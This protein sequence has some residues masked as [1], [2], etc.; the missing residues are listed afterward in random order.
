MT[1]RKSNLTAEKRGPV[2]PWAQRVDLSDLRYERVTNATT[3]KPLNQ[4]HEWRGCTH[5]PGSLAA[6]DLPRRGLG[7]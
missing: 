4:A 6:F 5:R 2:A 1:R 3:T 7:C